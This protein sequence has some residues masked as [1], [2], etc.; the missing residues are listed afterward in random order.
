MSLATPMAACSGS[1]TTLAP[2]QA[3][4][5]TGTYVITAAYLTHGKVDYS[6]TAS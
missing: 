4:T 2:G 1:A 6:A 3:A 5:F